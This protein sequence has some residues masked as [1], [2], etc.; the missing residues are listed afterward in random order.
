MKHKK[1]TLRLIN[2]WSNVNSQKPNGGEDYD[3]YCGYTDAKAD[4]LYSIMRIIKS[5]IENEEEEF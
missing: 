1:E 3:Y 5:I 2:V 4:C